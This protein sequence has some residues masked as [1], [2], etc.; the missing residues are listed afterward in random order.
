MNW[1]KKSRKGMT[2]VEIT[3]VTLILGVV[4][5]A[6]FLLLT[7]GTEEF[8]FSRR[9][10]ELN[11]SGRQVIEALT[12]S[13]IW[14]GYMPNPNWDDD[15]WHPITLAAINEIEFYADFDPYSPAEAVLGDTEYRR[16]KLLT[17]GHV[18]ITDRTGAVLQTVGSD[19]T[20]LSFTYLDEDG[21]TIDTLTT[22]EQRDLIR[23][24][25]IRVEL[26]SEYAGNVY[27]TVMFTTVTPRNLGLSHN[28]DPSFGGW[29][30][31]KGNI[32][33]NVPGVAGSSVPTIHESLMV[34]RLCLWGYTVSLLTDDCLQTY[35]YSSINLLILRH[36]ESGIHPSPIAEFLKTL[37][38]PIITMNAEEAS[39]T[40]VMGSSFKDETGTIMRVIENTHPVNNDLPDPLFSVYSEAGEHSV[41]YDFDAETTL[42]TKANDGDDYSGVC[43]QQIGDDPTRRVHYS[44]WE[45]LKYTSDGWLL[46]SNT[47]A[48]G[49][50]YP[51]EDIGEPIMP[52]EDFER[53]DEDFPEMIITSIEFEATFCPTFADS[54]TYED[55]DVYMSAISD[56]VFAATGE[57]VK[58]TM[59]Y[60][61]ADVEWTAT[62]E[63]DSSCWNKIVLD[64]PFVLPAGE[65]LAIK[66]EKH[67]EDISGSFEWGCIN[68]GTDY[69][70]RDNSDNGTDP[71]SLPRNSFLPVIKLNTAIHG[72]IEMIERSDSRE[73]VPVNTMF[74]YSDFEG[75]YTPDLF[76]VNEWVHSGKK[77]DWQF[78]EPVF[79][80]DIDPALTVDNGDR[81]A[82]TDLGIVIPPDL[83]GSYD[84]YYENDA[85]SLL[86]SPAYEMPAAGTY[87]KITLRHYRCVRLAPADNGLVWVGFSDTET[88]PD[89]VSTDWQLVRTYIDNQNSWAYE[90][91][92]ISS[93]F[94]DYSTSSYFF[95]R[96]GLCS[97]LN[98]FR[99]GW[100]LDNIQIYGD[101]I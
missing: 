27:Q 92:D 47:V 48:W 38:V 87:N 19:L 101:S 86:V 9:Q 40:F 63:A 100:N 10:N 97:N 59:D 37:Q 70:C 7:R 4:L 99:G 42:L 44:P 94:N 15:E 73:E 24:I 29:P 67:D 54:F 90:N 17:S 23:H 52:L 58:A 5:G 6:V 41:L 51:E 32:A 26:S 18:Q 98:D 56:D 62:W 21:V 95:L 11:I 66:I 33:F 55:V 68:T 72:T 14:A 22:E 85:F 89:S 61:A 78:G 8:H 71:N 45:A 91:K 77:D 50:W 16:I 83:P 3:V 34:N 53:T 80:P 57:W 30:E 69:Q 74:K 75:I 13:I 65:N 46:F 81:I 64:T 88:P 43:F 96:Y 84:G 2:L 60:V 39:G 31:I 36:M 49:I 12:N 82:G 1:L 76:P 35:D 28:I 20:N 79:V 25:Q 93:K